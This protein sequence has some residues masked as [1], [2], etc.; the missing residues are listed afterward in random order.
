[1][2]EKPPTGPHRSPRRGRVSAAQCPGGE[3]APSEPT[4]LVGTKIFAP[5]RARPAVISSPS[6]TRARRRGPNQ[7]FQLPTSGHSSRH[8]SKRAP[9]RVVDEQYAQGLG[10]KALELRRRETCHALSSAM[11]S[12]PDLV[13]EN[14]R[15]GGE[16]LR[17]T[18]YPHPQRN[19][20]RAF[21]RAGAGFAA[22]VDVLV[23]S[24]IARR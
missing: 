19:L 7:S 14:S 23:S 13:T 9:R 8:S 20:F 15:R 5:V 21:A 17:N 1:M 3:A 10:R 18:A 6:C 16:K 4:G 12:K 2:P 22:P 11:S 24:V